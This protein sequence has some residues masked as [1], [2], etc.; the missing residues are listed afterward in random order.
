MASKKGIAITLLCI[1]GMMQNALAQTNIGFL[2][3]KVAL[4]YSTQIS[5]VNFLK[6]FD[7]FTHNFSAEFSTQRYQS[8]TLNLGYKKTTVP[9]GTY[10]SQNEFFT[11]DYSLNGQQYDVDFQKMGGTADFR[12]LLMGIKVNFFY[13][14]KTFAAPNGFCQYLKA[15]IIKVKPLSNNYQYE[16]LSPSN[17]SQAQIDN[18]KPPAIKNADVTLFNVGFG[19]AGKKMLSR[20]VFFSINAEANVNT[21]N[22]LFA[23][24]EDY[25]YTYDIN[26]DLKF[27][28]RS[29]TKFKHL[30]SLGMGVGILL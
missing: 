7:V 17:Y 6:S 22:L 1:V 28:G 5:L 26:E 12:T 19:L 2:G 8:I 4:G 13:H 24:D 10:E 14:G 23:L 11:Q 15:D 18:A 16:L 30:L 9:M 25:S 3:K 21:L 29:V 27:T 20:S